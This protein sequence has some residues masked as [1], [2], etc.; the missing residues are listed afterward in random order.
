[1]PN[2]TAI[3]IP[4]DL[5]DPIA[6]RR[7][8]SI[9]IEKVN[10]AYNYTEAIGFADNDKINS[11]ID[12]INS[13]D[14]KFVRLDSSNLDTELV[15][16]TPPSVPSPLGLVTKNYV[17]NKYTPQTAPALIASTSTD[18]EVK[19]IADKVDELINVLKLSGLLL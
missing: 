8:L 13:L 2:S 17:D 9:L 14:S 12:V 5:T 19:A 11:L 10:I 16:T 18:A 7:L 3:T 1:M 4:L 6:L 15:Y